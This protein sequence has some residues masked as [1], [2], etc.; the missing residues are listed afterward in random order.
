MLQIT[1]ERQTNSYLQIFII[2]FQIPTTRV[3]DPDPGFP[4]KL[5][6]PDPVLRY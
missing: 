1:T 5:L 2:M 4:K 3:A 6:E